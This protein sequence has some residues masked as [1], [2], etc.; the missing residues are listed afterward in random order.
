MAV[1]I[2]ELPAGLRRRHVGPQKQQKRRREAGPIDALPT[3]KQNRVLAMVEDVNQPPQFV[4]RRQAVCREGDVFLAD[5][6][7]AGRP[8]L[9]EIPILIGTGAAEI[10]D[11]SD[12]VAADGVEK[13]VVRELGAAKGL[14]RDDSV[15]VAAEEEA[16][17]LHGNRGRRAEHDAPCGRPADLR[18]S[19]HIR[20]PS[21]G[22]AGARR[23]AAA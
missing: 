14:A 21:V 4:R 22:T 6:G 17:D 2:A 9:A 10:D 5:V 8:A 3:M 7:V 1:A 19:W 12:V 13:P 20:I 16:T 23:R 11:G 18:P 15:P